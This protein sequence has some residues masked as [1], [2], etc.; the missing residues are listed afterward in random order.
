MKDLQFT[1]QHLVYGDKE[2]PLRAA[3][4]PILV[5]NRQA[6]QDINFLL[7]QYGLY[8]SRD[9]VIGGEISM[10]YIVQ[11]AGN[12]AP[13]STLFTSGQLL[14]IASNT[15]LFSI[16]GTLYGGDGSTTFALPDLRDDLAIGAGWGPGLDSIGLGQSYGADTRPLSEINLP[17]SFGGNGQAL[18]NYETSLGLNY[19]IHTGGYGMDSGSANLTGSVHLWAGNFDPNGAMI[20]DGRLLPISGYPLLYSI[21]GT[22]YG[23]D[24]VT[25][26][27]IPDLRGRTII[28]SD[29][30][31]PVG[32]VV[33]S[34][35][36]VFDA[37][38]MPIEVGGDG[39]AIDNMQPGLVMQVLVAMQGVFPSRNQE[40][41]KD[42]EPDDFVLSDTATLGQ[43][44]FFAGA[45]VP[46]GFAPAQGQLVSIASNTA[47]FSL[48]G[49]MYGGDGRTTFALPDLG[50]RAAMH[51]GGTP[52]STQGDNDL[53]LSYDDVPG[54]TQDGDE[55][56]DTIIGS[57]RADTFNGLGGYDTLIGN[58]GNDF[59]YG[60]DQDDTLEGGAGFDYLLG[61]SGRDTM[62]GG[63]GN[64]TYDYVGG[65]DTI[66]ELAGGGN[67]T[68]RTLRPDF[69]LGDNL[70]NLILLRAAGAVGEGNALAND[71]IGNIGDDVLRGFDGDDRLVGRAGEDQLAGGNGNDNLFG[72]ANDDVLYGGAGD[73]RLYGEAQNDVLYGG[74]GADRLVG[75]AGRDIAYGGGGADE[76]VFADGDLAGR[77]YTNSD[78]I[79]DF[80]QAASDF[81]NLKGIDAIA[82]GGHD[83]FTWI[84]DAVFSGT[85]GEL[86]YDIRPGG[87]TMVLGDTD[88]DGNADVVIRLEGQIDLT[89]ADFII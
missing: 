45:G 8:P 10:G 60:G 54:R 72:G 23:G 84:G 63:P 79:A 35:G 19:V 52:G 30:G 58:G 80:N 55:G 42:L 16:M 62:V 61:G 51:A 82:G 48:L 47:L 18:N 85:A 40:T 24:G 3:E 21:I 7:I 4:E 15:A 71:I 43:I 1:S 2:M 78:V 34:D 38:G 65:N 41:P 53:Y 17:T 26:F 46:T 6:S 87:F 57:D 37:D 5:D 14:S 69:T 39:A 44:I 31:L 20:C 13:R 89:V 12:F 36:L 74:G 49:T 9:Q 64:D 76:F 29:S 22:T 81:I 86:R 25:S 88:G 77:A 56:Q 32:S 73:D 59:L 67:D 50:G 68:V 75:G 66:V 70:E 11:F 28:G 33:G 27:A 83:S